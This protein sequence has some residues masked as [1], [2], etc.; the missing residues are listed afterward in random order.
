MYMEYRIR[1]KNIRIYLT[2]PK[3]MIIKFEKQDGEGWADQAA[4]IQYIKNNGNQSAADALDAV[5]AASDKTE[6]HSDLTF[7]NE[8][9]TVVMRLG[10]SDEAY[11]RLV[12]RHPNGDPEIL[13][14]VTGVN[15]SLVGDVTDQTNEQ[16][17]AIFGGEWIEEIPADGIVDDI[18]GE[19]PLA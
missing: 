12:E 2:M 4:F 17:D 13:S 1:C 10:Y 16:L 19:E 14:P 9:R 3:L 11:T 15:K 18:I 5:V 7:Q 8:G 6:V